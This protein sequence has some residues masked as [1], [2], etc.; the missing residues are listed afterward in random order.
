MNVADL[1]AWEEEHGEIPEGA[2]V[3]MRSGF[4]LKYGNKPAYLGWPAGMEKTNPKDT[5]NLHFPGFGGD[6][7]KWLVEK[8][9]VSARVLSSRF[10]APINDVSSIFHFLRHPSFDTFCPSWHSFLNV[11]KGP[12]FMDVFK[13]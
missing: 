9:K 1:E 6:A 3:I 12:L 10:R 13:E 8:R 2:V 4:G 7:A 11:V 5:D